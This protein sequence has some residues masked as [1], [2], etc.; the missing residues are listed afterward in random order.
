MGTHRALLM[1]TEQ[2][3]TEV[4]RL[5]MAQTVQRSAYLLLARQM[6]LKGYAD[7]QMLVADV[8]TMGKARPGRDWQDGHGRLAAE[9]Q[10]ACGQPSAR[11]RSQRHRLR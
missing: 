8:E 10:A 2:L 3:T 4:Q 11:Q 5:H 7:P 9:L 1:A 6:C